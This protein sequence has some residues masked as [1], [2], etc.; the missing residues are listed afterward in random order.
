MPNRI[1]RGHW[2]ILVGALNACTDAPAP[3]TGADT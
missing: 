1:I 3:G 2:L